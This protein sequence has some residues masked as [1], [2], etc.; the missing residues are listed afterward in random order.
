VY[1]RYA[2]P[3]ST[4]LEHI[5][6]EFEGAE[7]DNAVTFG[8]GMAAIHSTFLASGLS[9]GDHV[10]ASRDL[11]GQTYTLLNGQMR[12]LGIETT[13]IDVTNLDEAIGA[14]EE[15]RPKL[16]LME[17]ISNPLLKVAPLRKIAERAHGAGALVMV[18]N[19]FAT[20][21]LVRPIEHGADIVVHSATKYR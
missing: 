9:V 6:A 4:E 11:Y 10:V 5:V 14:I 17:T 20:P 13:F 7:P 1:S 19:T 18:D 16:V 2:N 15:A 3:T 12:R 21:Y 8:S